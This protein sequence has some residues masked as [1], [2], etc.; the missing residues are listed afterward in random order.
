VRCP[1]TKQATLS[2][3]VFILVGLLLHIPFSAAEYSLDGLPEVSTLRLYDNN[4]VTDQ[5]P[6]NDHCQHIHYVTVTGDLPDLYFIELRI[7]WGILNTTGVFID[8]G[9]INM[10]ATHQSVTPIQSNLTLYADDNDTAFGYILQSPLLY[11]TKWYTGEILGGNY[12][13][14]LNEK[15]QMITARIDSDNSIPESNETNNNLTVSVLPGVTFTGRVYTIQNGT[16]VPYEGIVQL[17]QYDTESL[18]DFGY[19]HYR[20]DP[21]GQYNMSLCPLDPLDTPMSYSI[22]AA[23]FKQTFTIVQTSEP[24]AAGATSPLDFIVEGSPPIQ[25]L[26]PIGRKSGLVNRNYSYMSGSLDPDGDTLSY[27]F[28]W[29]DGTF[30]DW[31]VPPDGGELIWAHHAW[32][33]ARQY[34]IEVLAKDPQGLISDWS[35]TRYIT[36]A[37]TRLTIHDALMMLME[38]LQALFP[39]F[40]LP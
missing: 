32:A 31:L 18:S 24:V 38:Q 20:S 39:W 36:V 28:K 9:V 40:S 8:Y 12:F 22:M 6:P 25:P 2:L 14:K 10:G 37:K 29:G 15:P 1:S 19:R 30:S 27:K 34:K 21:F 23:D 17:N 3:H 4:Q 26:K 33:E 11:P 13:F 5:L 7:W 35:E 16:P